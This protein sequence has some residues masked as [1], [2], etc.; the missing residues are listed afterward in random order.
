MLFLEAINIIQRGCCYYGGV[1][2]NDDTCN[3]NNFDIIIMIIINNNNNLQIYFF[4]VQIFISYNRNYPCAACRDEA[5]TITIHFSSS[6]LQNP[7]KHDGMY[8]SNY[9]HDMTMN[10]ISSLFIVL[11][12]VCLII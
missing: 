6:D 12:G 5:K 10:Y 2:M 9:N 11:E 3:N 4:S 7:H 1:M 8:H